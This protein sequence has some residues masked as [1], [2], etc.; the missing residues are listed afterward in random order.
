MKIKHCKTWLFLSVFIFLFGFL[1][2][3]ERAYAADVD[4][5]S[6]LSEVQ[7]SWAGRTEPVFECERKWNP[8]THQYEV[9]DGIWKTAQVPLTIDCNP[10]I[11]GTVEITLDFVSEVSAIDADYR[12]VSSDGIEEL[13]NR[14]NQI[15]FLAT[16]PGTYTVDF[17]L[18]NAR[19]MDFQA[20]LE[21]LGHFQVTAE[22]VVMETTAYLGAQTELVKETLS[23]NTLTQE[24]SKDSDTGL[25][26][27]IDAVT[28]QKIFVDPV[29]RKPLPVD[30]LTGKPITSGTTTGQP[31]NGAA[32][33][34]TTTETPSTEK[35]ITPPVTDTGQGSTI[36]PPVNTPLEPPPPT[37]T[38]EKPQEPVV[39]STPEPVADESE[40]ISEQSLKETDMDHIS[41]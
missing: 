2:I 6:D 1:G 41:E 23:E 30:S 20:T 25:F 35:P 29:T 9:G 8:D 21:E 38:E 16:E 22:T 28:G 31:D 36:P 26:Y 17:S 37:I 14:G 15:T 40:Q 18:M 24:L 5:T 7:I 12:L 33:G 13:H 3:K 39:E 10:P 4:L 19:K 27:I 32:S 11:G 34:T